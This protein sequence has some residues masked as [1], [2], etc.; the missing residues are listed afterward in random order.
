MTG[1]A[2]R[3]AK[4]RHVPYSKL[5]AW[6]S[7]ND[8]RQKHLAELLNLGISTINQKLNATGGDFSMAEVREICKHYG[9]SAD[10]FFVTQRVS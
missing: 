10:S 6:M 1:K 4:K 9:I 5:K 7:E 2:I 3:G 8:V